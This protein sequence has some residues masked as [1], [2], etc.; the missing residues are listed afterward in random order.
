MPFSIV[1]KKQPLTLLWTHGCASSQQQQNRVFPWESMQLCCSLGSQR[2][3][4]IIHIPGTCLETT[5][6]SDL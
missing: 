3:L 4:L 2:P 1:S 5:H 6:F